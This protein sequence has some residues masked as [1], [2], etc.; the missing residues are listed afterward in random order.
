MIIVSIILAILIIV[1]T[2]LTIRNK[3]NESELN[4]C[5][6]KIEEA[7]KNIDLYLLKK[8]EFYL[9]TIDVIKNSNK[10]KYGKKNIMINL[11]KN[12]SKKLT[13]NQI[14]DELRNIDKEFNK[15]LEDDPKLNDIKEIKETK[16]M[17]NN[18]ETDLIASIKYF[19]ENVDFLNKNKKNMLNNLLHKN[20]VIK[21]YTKYE[22]VN[23]EEFEI[24]KEENNKKVN[25]NN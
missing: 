7:N 16:Y 14:Y 17:L 13:S 4:L 5:L 2:I 1:S 18:N 11:I 6:A 3:N 21:D 20:K 19:N 22:I 24:L 9:N 12:K 23:E 25:L 10:R 8:S 15:L